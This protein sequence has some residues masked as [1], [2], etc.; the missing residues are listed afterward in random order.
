MQ[1]RRLEKGFTLIELLVVIAIIAILAAMLLPALAQAKDKAR[2]MG[3]VNNQ[4]QLSTGWFLYS[5]DFGGRLVSNTG[6]TE[7]K[8]S[9]QSWVNN[10]EDWTSSEENTNVAYLKSG[11][12]A[13][14]VAFS[15]GIYRCPSDQSMAEC[16][17]R[18]RSYSMNSL[19]G[20]PGTK[21]DQDNPDMVQFFKMTSIV[22]PGMMFVF[23][24]EHPDT[25]ND[26]FFLNSWSTYKWG[27]L[28]ASYHA[29]GADMAFADGHLDRHRWQ[30]PDTVREPKKGAAGGGFD[31]N[32]T[33]DFQWL[34][35]RAGILK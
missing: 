9:R 1:T 14:Y 8:A 24:E 17:L 33:T 5:D 29:S 11:K 31:A 15:T 4:K 32:P 26:G 16:G 28:P 7:T 19:M 34:K 2:A 3:C 6:L 27:N 23:I 30:V 22:R 21:L 25:I 20:N 35:D 10:A 18:I 12:L 13:S